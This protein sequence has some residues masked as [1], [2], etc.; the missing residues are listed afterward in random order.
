MLQG[1]KRIVFSFS[2]LN[3]DL[4]IFV[5]TLRK[6]DS[7]REKKR[8][9]KRESGTRKNKNQSVAVIR[10]C[11]SKRLSVARIELF[12]IG[13]FTVVPDFLLPNG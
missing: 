2:F 8:M 7:L 4:Y 13:A 6:S 9:R 10:D 11:A 12:I 3:T 5:V 1:D